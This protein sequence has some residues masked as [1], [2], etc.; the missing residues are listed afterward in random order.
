MANRRKK[1]VILFDYEPDH[2][3]PV[4]YIKHQLCTRNE[5]DEDLV[6]DKIPKLNEDA[7]PYEILQF[8]STFQRVRKVMGWTSVPKLYQKFPIHLHNYHLDVSELITGDLTH[9]VAY[10]NAQLQEFKLE[11]RGYKYEEQM[12]NLRSLKK[13]GKMEP[14]QFLLML[15]LANRIAIQQPDA[16]EFEQGFLDLQLLVAMPSS[17]QDHFKDT[18]LDVD[19]TTIEEIR[20]YLDKQSNKNPFIPKNKDKGNN[21]RVESNTRNK[22]TEATLP[23]TEMDNVTTITHKDKATRLPVATVTAFKT[24]TCAPYQDIKITHGVNAA[25]TGSNRSF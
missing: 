24:P 11:L 16:P 1:P 9:A 6:E 5:D 10:F 13:P 12:N 7:S 21:D 25:P 23:T 15:R 19:N 2:T 14:S 20:N 3:T 22:N 4:V 17:W 18:N 8:L